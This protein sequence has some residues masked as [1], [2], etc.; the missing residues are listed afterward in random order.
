MSAV[1]NNAVATT[2]EQQ[3]Q[4]QQ[5]QHQFAA[6]SPA[7]SSFPKSSYRSSFDAAATG[8]GGFESRSFTYQPS[9]PSLATHLYD[10]S[11]HNPSV[12]SNHTLVNSHNSQ[13]N[14]NG[15]MDSIDELVRGNRPLPSPSQQPPRPS[16]SLPSPFRPLVDPKSSTLPSPS[17]GAAGMWG[18]TA[19]MRAQSRSQSMQ[20]Y[21]LDANV[22]A[23]PPVRVLPPRKNG[24]WG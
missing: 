3:H 6:A 11:R 1:A 10:Q 22:A 14:A 7:Q 13:A 18:P 15:Q 4:A 9:I 23:S 17:T 16:A 21:A 2:M 5:Q 8:K 20:G 12:H 24:I 19:G